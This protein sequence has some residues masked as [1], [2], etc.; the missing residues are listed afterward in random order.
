M[1]EMQGD[2]LEAPCGKFVGRLGRLQPLYF[3]QD[4]YFD[5]LIFFAGPM[6]AQ[7][8]WL[9][10]SWKT[11]K[12]RPEPKDWEMILL[13]TSIHVRTAAILLEVCLITMSNGPL[14]FTPWQD[15][16][17]LMFCGC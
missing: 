5:Q 7:R 15:I 3:I 17:P 2:L 12:M 6:K 9:T 1:L 10:A 16:S 13:Q 11:F 14:T 8:R 4:D